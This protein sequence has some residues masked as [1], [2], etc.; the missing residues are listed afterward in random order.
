M[1]VYP[2][3]SPLRRSSVFEKTSAQT[4]NGPGDVTGPT[5]ERGASIGTGAK[6]IGPVVVGAGASVGAGAVVVDDV[7]AGATVAGI[8]ARRV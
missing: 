4:E 7:P 1:S 8:P 2:S 3:P 6:V 5:I